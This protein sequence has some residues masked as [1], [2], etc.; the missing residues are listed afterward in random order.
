MHLS[1]NQE[2]TLRKSHLFLSKRSDLMLSRSFPSLSICFIDIRTIVSQLYLKNCALVT[3]SRIGL[4]DNIQSR[5][6]S[7]SASDGGMIKDSA[8]DIIDA[9]HL[10]GK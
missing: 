4:L 1:R 2:V 5:N 9:F 7:L 8:W 10:A 6:L 3:L